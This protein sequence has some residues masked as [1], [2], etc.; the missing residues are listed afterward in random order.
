MKYIGKKFAIFI[1]FW[2]IML[3]G[4]VAVAAEYED[5]SQ[6]SDA[7]FELRD[8]SDDGVF[9]LGEGDQQ[10][11]VTIPYINEYEFSV[12]SKNIFVAS[13]SDIAGNGQYSYSFTL[14][15]KR[16]GE[17]TVTVKDK[18]SGKEVSKTYTVVKPGL[19]LGEET[20]FSVKAG[21]KLLLSPWFVDREGDTLYNISDHFTFTSSK[22]KVATISSKGKIIGKKVGVTN[23]TITGEKTGAKKKIKV[24]VYG[25]YTMK[26]KGIK[27]GTIDAVPSQLKLSKTSISHTDYAGSYSKKQVKDA[28]LQLK[29]YYNI[30]NSM[31][32]KYKDSGKCVDNLYLTSDGK[33]L[34]YFNDDVTVGK[35]H[36]G[37]VSFSIGGKKLKFKYSYRLIG[38][39]ST[40]YKYTQG[41]RK[42]IKLR[43]YSG[44]VKYTSSNRSVATIS[45]RGVLTAKAPG[46]AVITARISGR[47]FAC[48]VNV[49]RN[50]NVWALLDEQ[51]YILNNW[52]YSQEQSKRNA[53][54]YYD[55]SSLVYRTFKKY[56]GIDFGNSY[57]AWSGSEAD[58]CDANVSQINYRY[59]NL[60]LQPADLGICYTSDWKNGSTWHATTFG[61]YQISGFN[62][63]GKPYI[64]EVW[65]N[66]SGGYTYFKV[67]R[68]LERANR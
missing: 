44:K 56:E 18:V 36:K 11:Y 39:T 20:S 31:F 22:P 41:D 51:A 8:N 43:G 16:E 12:E 50:K 63:K 64:S 57:S 52:S 58:W 14:Y 67:F 55:C 25:R 59:G 66:G 60:K 24:Y 27:I 13:V 48:V 46:A 4:Q 33:L 53:D 54:G 61:Y 5:E 65:Y 37:T 26:N 23:I 6:T 21:K 38:F 3:F 42:N 10:I 62:E 28:V 17:T 45:S 40:A 9:Y 29:N 15:L 30:S 34:V 49:A 2:C 35:K 47:K 19:S 32:L 68:P 7:T 1:L